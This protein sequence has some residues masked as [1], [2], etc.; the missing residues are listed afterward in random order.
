MKCKKQKLTAIN[1]WRVD[2]TTAT[3]CSQTDISPESVAETLLTGLACK[4]TTRGAPTTIADCNCVQ[5]LHV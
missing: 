2:W 1:Y 5:P 3:R 4:R